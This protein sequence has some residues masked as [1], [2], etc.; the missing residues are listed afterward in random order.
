MSR[1]R[2]PTV[3]AHPPRPTAGS[4]CRGRP[5][6]KTRATPDAR[7][8]LRLSAKTCSRGRA[9]GTGPSAMLKRIGPGSATSVQGHRQLKG[10]A[11]R[12]ARIRPRW[13]GKIRNHGRTQTQPA[14]TSRRAGPGSE[15]S[16][17]ERRQIRG[18]ATRDART[19]P[20]SF[21]KT[22]NHSRT[23][24]LAPCNLNRTS[25]IFPATRLVRHA[26]FQT[27]IRRDS[28][29]AAIPHRAAS[30][31][32]MAS[33]NSLLSRRRSRPRETKGASTT[34]R[35]P[36]PRA[37]TMEAQDGTAF[38]RN[39]KPPR[40]GEADFITEELDLRA[41]PS[42]VLNGSP[43]TETQVILHARRCG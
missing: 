11:T 14:A 19:P 10:A 33:A 15:T 12:G 43:I 35:G 40:S 22:R 31:A 38:S 23:P 16:G 8:P 5:G 2:D 42:R 20:R 27:I 24:G 7:L 18:A 26:K 9:R 41:I 30:R 32:T 3:L 34:T 13:S 25:V 28:T 36:R 21:V 37:T 17:R 6:R 39:G 4:R 1:L 29:R